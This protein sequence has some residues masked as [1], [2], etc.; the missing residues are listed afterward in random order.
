VPPPLKLPADPGE[1]LQ[2]L[3]LG[4]HAVPG[5]KREAMRDDHVVKV[6]DRLGAQ[7]DVSHASELVERD[8]LAPAGAGQVLHGTLVGARDAT[9]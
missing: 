1:V 4:P 3:Q 5:I 9:Y 7:P 8:G 6:L 2:D